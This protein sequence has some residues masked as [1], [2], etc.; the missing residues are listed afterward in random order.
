MV[1][2]SLF[3]SKRG[4]FSKPLI[5]FLGSTRSP[6]ASRKI[7]LPSPEKP[8]TRNMPWRSSMNAMKPGG[9]WFQAK[10]LPRLQPTIYPCR[11]TLTILADDSLISKNTA[12]TLLS[13]TPLAL[14]GE[15]IQFTP[16]FHLIPGNFLLPLIPL[17]RL[18]TKPAYSCCFINS[19]FPVSK[20][21]YISSAQV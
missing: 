21:F 7:P 13:K 10:V 8:K 12:V 14:F 2:V 1:Q 20:W 18:S 6:M 3:T 17:V 11:S 15:T 16:V 5:F 19:T 4:K 9:V